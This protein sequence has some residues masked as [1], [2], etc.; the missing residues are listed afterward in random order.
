MQNLEDRVDK[1]DK[2][3]NVT[4]ASDAVYFVNKTFKGCE[5]TIALVN[6]ECSLDYCIKFGS[7]SSP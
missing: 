1:L 5:D 3:E 4:S 7:F 2:C 6:T